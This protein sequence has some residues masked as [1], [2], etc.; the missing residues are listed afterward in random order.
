MKSRSEQK[1]GITKYA[2][3]IVYNNDG[4]PHVF[5]HPFPMTY[6]QLI[7]HIDPLAGLID[8]FVYQMYTGNTFLH[9]TKV[10][11]FYTGSYTRG[12]E[13]GGPPNITSFDVTKNV[14]HLI[15]Q[16]LDPMRV[17]C[18]RAHQNGMKFFAGLRMNDLHDLWFK[19]WVCKAKKEHPEWLI[20]KKGR[21]P[22]PATT[23]WDSWD[24]D[25]RRMAWDFTH[26]EVVEMRLALLKET[27]QKYDIDGLELD[28]LRMPI[29]FPPDEEKKY[30]HILTELVSRVRNMLDKKGKLIGRPLELGAIIPYSPQVCEE[31]GI[32]IRDWLDEDL[33]N[34]IAPREMDLFLTETP[35][36]DWKS[37]LAGCKTQL[38]GATFTCGKLN[39]DIYYALASR[40]RQA[41]VNGM[42]LFNF[43]YRR[44]PESEDS[45]ALLKGLHNP[46]TIARHDK[47][48]IL[49]S[50]KHTCG[51]YVSRFDVPCYLKDETPIAFFLGDDFTVSSHRP[52]PSEVIIQLYIQGY[53]PEADE[54][55]F[56]VNGQE[57]PSSRIRLHE[58][59]NMDLVNIGCWWTKPQPV[60][61]IDLDMT[62]VSLHTGKNRFMIKVT[63]RSRH[64]ADIVVRHFGIYVKYPHKRK[65]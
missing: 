19:E 64:S 5:Y 65:A 9:D 54:I 52:A 48:Y 1:K 13:P 58:E 8:I 62:D 42:H 47:H 33:L 22:K 63:K 20:G 28:F 61:V 60:T 44:P 12:M 17:L 7:S 39:E 6:E 38:L 56:T 24:P 55:S 49:A 50:R 34:Y 25:P 35:F 26:P 57:I 40:C 2:W 29:F 14:R 32:Q 30:A 45:T 27:I 41:G 43:N 11:E 36:E 31:V 15:D 10:G 23:E 59:K 21:A 18:E 4:S 37:L 16:G 51:S 46:E 3:R 53:T